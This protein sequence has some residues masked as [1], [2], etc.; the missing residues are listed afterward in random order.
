[1]PLVYTRDK[2]DLGNIDDCWFCLEPIDVDS[3]VGGVP[4]CVI[5]ENGHRVHRR[6]YDLLP[7]KECGTC[8]SI[9]FKNC[10]TNH[11]GYSYVPRTGGKRKT[12]KTR[13][14][15]KK[16]SKTHKKRNSYKRK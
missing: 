14:N 15:K 13:K 2:A 11:L 16:R 1:M 4:D 12:K 8:R 3:V 5:C 7:V 6:C 10:H 9:I